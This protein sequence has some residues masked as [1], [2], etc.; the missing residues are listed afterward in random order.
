[1]SPSASPRSLRKCPN[2]KTLQTEQHSIWPRAKRRVGLERPQFFGF[3]PSKKFSGSLPPD[4]GLRSA[5]VV[6]DCENALRRRCLQESV[7][8]VKLRERVLSNRQYAAPHTT[9]TTRLHDER[10]Q[11]LA[12][13]LRNYREKSSRTGTTLRLRTR[14]RNCCGSTRNYKEKGRLEGFPRSAHGCGGQI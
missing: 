12:T 10:R 7:L 2:N 5:R 4:V 14:L 6:G 1:M 8:T 11:V 3:Q 9:C 13:L